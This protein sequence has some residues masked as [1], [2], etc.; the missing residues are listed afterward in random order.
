MYFYALI[1]PTTGICYEVIESESPITEDPYCIQ[2]NEYDRTY[3]TRKKYENGNWVDTNPI[4]TQSMQASAI[5]IGDVWLDA[6]IYAMEDDIANHTHT[7]SNVGAIAVDDIATV[8]EVE[9][10]LGI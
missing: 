9:T 2:L 4:E 1:D 6:K 8:S 3:I 10:Y 5:G 7:A